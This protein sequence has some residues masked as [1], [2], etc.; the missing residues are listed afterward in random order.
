[1]NEQE[2]AVYLVRHD[3]DVSFIPYHRYETQLNF[4][5]FDVGGITTEY[6]N[7]APLTAYLFSDRGIYRPGDTTHIGMIIKQPYVMPQLA[8]LPLEVTI[9]D[10]RG[11]MIKDEK[12][13]LNEL[14]YHTFDFQTD[15][16]SPTGQYS[17]N[18]FIV[19]DNQRNSLIGSTSIRVAEFLPDRM[20]ITAHL[21]QEQTR[22]WISPTNLTAKIDLWNLYGA[23]AADH[24]VT[25]K[26]L[27]TPK[28]VT[29]KEFP[30]Y[31]FIDPLLNPK[32]P[33]KVFTENLNET[34]TN[35][36][37]QAELDL[38]LDRFAKATY[39]LTVFAEGFEAEGGRSVTTQVSALVSPLA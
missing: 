4:S 22:G 12:F 21:S 9:I 36:Q 27:L 17:V 32:S 39:Q 10:P 18:L 19:K 13:T 23:P 6:A 35:N 8:G 34:R 15:A 14:G 38:K 7:Q 1:V 37:G 11:T 3:N 33:P 29:F 2:P 5:R 25:G 16:T 24:R 20:R 28:A 30:D 26:L 31:T